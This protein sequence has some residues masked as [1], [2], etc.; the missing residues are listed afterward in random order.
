MERVLAD[1]DAVVLEADRLEPPAVAA[2]RA[3]ALGDAD[4]LLDAGELFERR[5]RDHA[6]RAEQVDLG[7]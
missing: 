2:D 7:E 4:H 5:R 6:G 1:A 3:E